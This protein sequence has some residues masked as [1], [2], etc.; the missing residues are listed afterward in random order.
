MF[1][2]SNCFYVMTLYGK[3]FQNVRWVGWTKRRFVLLVHFLFRSL[4]YPQLLYT[5][6]N[7]ISAYFQVAF[8]RLS[9][10][11]AKKVRSVDVW[12]IIS[13]VNMT[14]LWHK[15]PRVLS[16]IYFAGIRLSVGSEEPLRPQQIRLPHRPVIFGGS[17]LHD[18]G[19]WAWIM[20]LAT[21]NVRI[22]GSF[23]FRL[24]IRILL[25]GLFFRHN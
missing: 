9:N 5:T 7:F 25:H 14:L 6:L 18:R 22:L 10:H 21:V 8:N 4:K 2:E 16:L 1:Q 15:L 17:F 20:Y 12:S 23:I 24:H 3:T 13:E 11:S 19:P